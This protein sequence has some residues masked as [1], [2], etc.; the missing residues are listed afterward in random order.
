MKS[1]AAFWKSISKWAV[2]FAVT[3]SLAIS[4]VYLRNLHV[5]KGNQIRDL[6]A[7][8]S[9][10]ETELEMIELRIARLTDRST[11]EQTLGARLD[12]FQP[13][14]PGDVIVIQPESR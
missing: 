14:A 4:Y 13:I 12:Q 5:T 11:L 6:E 7:S 10:V 8:I 3:C 9:D 2:V 1:H